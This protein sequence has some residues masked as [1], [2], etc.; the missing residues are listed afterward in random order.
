LISIKWIS[1]NYIQL[2]QI[3]TLIV[4]LGESITRLTPTKSDDGFMSRVGSGLDGILGALKVPNLRKRIEAD[5]GEP[6]P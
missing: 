3:L 4:V 5:N 6:D 2:L 1:E